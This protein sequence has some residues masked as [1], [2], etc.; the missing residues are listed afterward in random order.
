MF[1]K[2]RGRVHWDKWVKEF[3]FVFAKQFRLL[4]NLKFLVFLFI[5]CFRK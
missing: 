2:G 3:S 1:S 4:K 5:L